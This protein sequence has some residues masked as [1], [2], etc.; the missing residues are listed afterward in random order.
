MENKIYE[1]SVV[2]KEE[3]TKSLFSNSPDSQPKRMESSDF[4]VM[5]KAMDEQNDQREAVIKS[6]RDVLK[7]AKRAIYDLHRAKTKSA[8]TQ[9]ENCAESC[10]RIAADAK[11][12]G[13]PSHELFSGMYGEC[14]EELC[15]AY[16]FLNW[17]QSSKTPEEG[18]IFISP[19]SE[20]KGMI[21]IT[22]QQYIGGLS[23]FTGEIGRYGVAQATARNQDEVRRVLDTMMEIQFYLRE[24]RA[25]LPN[26]TLKKLFAMG[27]NIEKMKYLL[28]EQVLLESRKSMKLSEAEILDEKEEQSENA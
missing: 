8:I 17:L 10:R 3:E 22:A 5:A 25:I 1:L 24:M 19:F 6:A 21:E 7:N 20:F 18:G 11:K 16:L 4:E 13:Y 27:K 2:L 14:A 15:E 26:K 28:Y 9:L 12:V 23:D